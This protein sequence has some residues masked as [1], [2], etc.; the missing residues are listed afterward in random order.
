MQGSLRCLACA[1]ADASAVPVGSLVGADTGAGVLGTGGH[2]GQWTVPRTDR[3][4][5]LVGDSLAMAK[6]QGWIG[7]GMVPVLTDCL[8]RS[9]LD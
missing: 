8:R 9:G 1:S 4:W 6:P 3:G 5:M 7:L 2:W